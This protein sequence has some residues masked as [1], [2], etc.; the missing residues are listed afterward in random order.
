MFFWN[1]LAFSMFQQML[2]IWSL[3]SLLFLNPA[4]RSGSSCWSLAWMI[5]S[6]T[7]LA[8]TNTVASIIVWTFF[9][10]A[11]LWDWNENGPFP[12]WWPLMSFPNLLTYWVQHFNSLNE[13]YTFYFV[14]HNLKQRKS[15]LC[16]SVL[17]FFPVG[18]NSTT[19][20]KN[21]E[22]LSGKKAESEG[23][24]WIG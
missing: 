23:R 7:L 14:F 5:L 21:S 11:L 9:D 3:V 15:K 13:A 16:Y 19:S 24:Q 1:S 18:I 10:I 12:F 4:C 8:Q 2:A 20:Q 22:T 17:L 6:T